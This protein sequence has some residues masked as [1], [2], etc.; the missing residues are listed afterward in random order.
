MHSKTAEIIFQ[1]NVAE[2]FTVYMIIAMNTISYT[3]HLRHGNL[4][5]LENDSTSYTKSRSTLKAS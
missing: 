1:P 4:G 3:Y 2:I 5:A